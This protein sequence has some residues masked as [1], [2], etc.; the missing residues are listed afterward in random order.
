MMMKIILFFISIFIVTLNASDSIEKKR[1]LVEYEE[2]KD[3][4]LESEAARVAKYEV[5][6]YEFI[7]D[8]IEYTITQIS[9]INV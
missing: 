3:V 4:I 8:F 1:S 9:C 6:M 2:T 7:N 5:I